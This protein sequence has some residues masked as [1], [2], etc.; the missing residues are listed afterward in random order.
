M[1]TTTS[2]RMTSA[3]ALIASA[4]ILA[5]GGC[6]STE[7]FTYQ[8]T[9]LT[10]QTVTLLDTTSGDTL[11]VVDVPVGQQL[12]MKFTERPATA[13]EF[14]S[15]IMRWTISPL[16]QPWQ[17]SPSEVRV[18][19][20]SSRRL[21]VSLRKSGEARQT[22]VIEP[23]KQPAGSTMPGIRAVAPVAPARPETPGMPGTPATAAPGTGSTPAPA[24]VLPDAKQPAPGQKP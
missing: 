8:S 1:N 12:D 6:Q 7:E 4:S 17:G 20:P 5:L 22:P 2:F 13:E 24:I 23:F 11:W 3:L 10:P 16:G 14:G 15:D 21:D 18:P 9:S 19:P